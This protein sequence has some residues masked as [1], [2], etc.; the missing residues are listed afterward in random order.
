L[1]VEPSEH[2]RGYKKS[3]L[4]FMLA[5]SDSQRNSVWRGRYKAYLERRQLVETGKIDPVQVDRC[6]TKWFDPFSSGD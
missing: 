2:S 4:S 3:A 6:V 5:L 1:Y